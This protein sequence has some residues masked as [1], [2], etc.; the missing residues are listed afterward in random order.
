M[1]S[2][3]KFKLSRLREIGWELWDPIGLAPPKDEFSDEYDTYLLQAAAQLWRSQPDA[4]VCDYLVRIEQEHMGL[5]KVSNAKERAGATVTAI[6]AYIC[7]LR[8]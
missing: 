5:P 4:E 1:T 8:G 7:E 3:P 6:N 2:L